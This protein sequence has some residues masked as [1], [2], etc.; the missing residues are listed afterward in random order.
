MKKK[1][2]M[3]NCTCLENLN[4]QRTQNKCWVIS[5]VWKYATEWS[6]MYCDIP[7]QGRSVQ[8]LGVI[9]SPVPASISRANVAERG[10]YNCIDTSGYCRLWGGKKDHYVSS[11]VHKSPIGCNRPAKWPNECTFSHNQVFCQTLTFPGCQIAHLLEQTPRV[12][13]LRSLCSW[14]RFRSRP[15]NLCFRSSLS[16]S[17]SAHVPYITTFTK[18][19]KSPISTICPFHNK[20][21][22]SVP[23]LPQSPW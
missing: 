9:W 13:R 17:P 15:V 12:K 20:H 2:T 10:A 22:V 11:E 4:T 18:A 19:T 3:L 6:V 1:K 14:P 21:L 8:V 16:L 7:D 23:L 5:E